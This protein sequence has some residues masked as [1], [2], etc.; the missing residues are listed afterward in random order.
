MTHFLRKYGIAGKRDR[1]IP[2]LEK[3]LKAQSKAHKAVKGLSEKQLDKIIGKWEKRLR[4]YNKVEWYTG[5]F[6]TNEVGVWKRAGN[7]PSS[8][9]NNSLA[10][11]AKMV[12]GAMHT[13]HKKLK[14]RAGRVIPII[15]GLKDVIKKDKYSMPIVIERKSSPVNRR[16]LKKMSWD[17]DDGN[18][19][20]IAFAVSGDKKFK[21]YVGITKKNL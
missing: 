10:H 12:R 2:S 19:R 14:K 11:T 17:L 16:W 1:K 4:A 6:S 7:L 13:N 8:W 18:M 3:Y 20:S 15:M 21:A 9:T 5:E